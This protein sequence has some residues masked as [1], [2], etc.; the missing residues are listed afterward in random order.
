MKTKMSMIFYD[1]IGPIAEIEYD[2][3]DDDM[4]KAAKELRAFMQSYRGFQ[5]R[6]LNFKDLRN[7][8]GESDV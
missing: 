6:I 2:C 5:V 7:D 3:K 8:K 4:N 1:S